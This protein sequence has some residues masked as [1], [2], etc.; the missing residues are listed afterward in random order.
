M[1]KGLSPVVGAVLLIMM[2]IAIG[3]GVF[4]WMRGSIT[5]AEEEAL[6]QQECQKIDFIVDDFC[7]E[8]I[9]VENIE[10]GESVGETRIRFNGRNDAS[11]PELYGFL[12]FIDYDGRT[13]SI[14]TAPYS[15]VE[16]Y[17]SRSVATSFIEDIENIR[18]IRVVPK[19]KQEREVFIC[20]EKEKIISWEGVQPC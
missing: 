3:S 15:E 10:T 11:E 2:V 5:K 20:E 4:L 1:K 17:E 7:Y 6:V 9:L 14:P 18:Q 12:V 16:G 13:I 19:I 8:D